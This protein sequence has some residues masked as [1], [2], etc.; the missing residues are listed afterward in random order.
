MYFNVA[1][2]RV[3]MYIHA[4]MGTESGAIFT[5]ECGRKFQRSECA[6]A[7]ACWLVHAKK[8]VDATL[9]KV[10]PRWAKMVGGGRLLQPGEECSN[11]NSVL[12]G[13]LCGGDLCNVRKCSHA[14]LYQVGR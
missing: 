3:E 6:D 11:C 4:T 12:G 14:R 2:E 9:R 8:C 5:C 13:W 1:A 10:R 7:A